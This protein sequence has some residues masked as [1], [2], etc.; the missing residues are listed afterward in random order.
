[1]TVVPGETPVTTP[2]DKPTVATPVA[3]LLQEPPGVASV[4]VMVAPVQTTIGPL[5][6]AGGVFTVNSM[7][8]VVEDK[9]LFEQR[10]TQR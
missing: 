9:P 10:I 3:L 1:M 2:V 4:S 8:A 5:M 7:E 6:A